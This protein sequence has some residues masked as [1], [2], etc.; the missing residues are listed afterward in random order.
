MEKKEALFV[1]KKGNGLKEGNLSSQHGSDYTIRQNFFSRPV[2]ATTFLFIVLTQ[3]SFVCF[4][5]LLPRFAKNVKTC[6]SSFLTVDFGAGHKM[7]R[8]FLFSFNTEC[9]AMTEYIYIFFI[10]K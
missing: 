6:F 10:L 4:V 9:L 7:W 2:Y 3:T 8:D 5:V 1:A